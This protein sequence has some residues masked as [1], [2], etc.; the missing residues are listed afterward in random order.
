MHLL[1]GLGNPGPICSGAAQG[2][3]VKVGELNSYSRMAA[4]AVPYRNGM[5]LAVEQIN[6]LQ[7]QATASRWD[8][9]AGFM[10][11]SPTQA[12]HPHTA[13]NGNNPKWLAPPGVVV[14]PR[15][16]VLRRRSHHRR[17]G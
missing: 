2:A 5:Q 9:I 17:C 4:F 8:L 15:A 14:P 3:P 6:A 16:A 11:V 13:R 10:T 7:A 12:K 1:V